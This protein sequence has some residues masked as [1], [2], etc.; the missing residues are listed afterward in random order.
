MCEEL[1]AEHALGLALALSIMK[2]HRI[3]TG[4]V[5]LSAIERLESVLAAARATQ[6]VPDAEAVKVVGFSWLNTAHFRRKVPTF[7]IPEHWH[8]LMTVAQHNLIMAATVPAGSRV[9]PVEP[10]HM[11]VVAGERQWESSGNESPDC[12][13]I[14]RAMLASAEGVK[15]E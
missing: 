9:V 13:A 15:D 3:E 7:C 12:A 1:K 10:T 5:H 6:A 11:M 14:Y 2:Q 4:G 8:A